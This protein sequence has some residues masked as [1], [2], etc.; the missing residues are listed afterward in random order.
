MLLT[1]IIWFLYAWNFV[2]HFKTKIITKHSIL[3]F[4][5][6]TNLI[7]FKI[8][9]VYIKNGTWLNWY[10][11]FNFLNYRIQVFYTVIKPLKKPF[12]SQN[13]IKLQLFKPRFALQ[14]RKEWP[15]PIRWR[16]F[17]R[18]FSR[19]WRSTPATATRGNPTGSASCCSASPPCAWCPPPPS[20]SCSS[21]GWFVWA[22]GTFFWCVAKT[23]DVK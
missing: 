13:N 7:P 4:N 3:I 18:R 8:K 2:K 21:S 12:K 15:T 5:V 16:N 17:R 11:I 9:N 10:K 22:A 6:Q 1:E 19:T 20:N 14:T 23:C